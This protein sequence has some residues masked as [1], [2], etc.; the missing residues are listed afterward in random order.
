MVMQKKERILMT[1]IGMLHHRRDPET[2]IKSYAYAAVAKA[3]GVSFFYFSPNNVN[4]INRTIRGKVLEDG[5]WKDRI[6]P[7]PDVIYNAGSPEKLAL[8]K[9]VVNELRKEI[10]FTT[11]SIG[12][13]WNITER[14]IEAKEFANYLIPTEIVK[15]AE[16]FYK[17]VTS[18]KKVVFKPVEGRKGKG[19]YFISK[20]GNQYDVQK[21]TT[22]ERYTKVQLDKLLTEKL[23]RGTFIIQPYIQSVIEIGAGF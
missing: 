18:F 8:S 3:E 19:I 21:D 13:K 9:E 14:L 23:A 1:T 15:N 11:H 2:V 7:F 17:Y 22:K 6:M 20:V 5:A 4:F 10:P 12:N 16:M